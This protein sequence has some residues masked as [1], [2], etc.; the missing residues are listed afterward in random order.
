L[1]WPVGACVSEEDSGDVLGAKEV[2]EALAL[3]GGASFGA[4]TF[5]SIEHDVLAAAIGTLPTIGT[6]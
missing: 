6:L 1:A 5:T 4:E 3:E 2:L